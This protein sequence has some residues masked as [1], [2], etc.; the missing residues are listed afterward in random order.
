MCPFGAQGWRRRGGREA[1]EEGVAKVLGWKGNGK[2][3]GKG[4]GKGWIGRLRRGRGDISVCMVVE[5]GVLDLADWSQ[6]GFFFFAF[7]F[8][9]GKREGVYVVGSCWER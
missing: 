9:L 8:F 1:R 2:G 6:L 4:K 3:K 5:G 7:P